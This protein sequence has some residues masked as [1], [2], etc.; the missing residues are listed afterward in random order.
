[1]V[2]KSES[3]VENG[4]F[5]SPSFS[6]AFDHPFGDAAFGVHSLCGLRRRQKKESAI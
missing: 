4:G 2:A 3:P 6:L 1:M 5:Y